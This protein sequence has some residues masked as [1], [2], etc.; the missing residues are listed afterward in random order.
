[1]TDH[2]P[3]ASQPI[4]R[5]VAP[6]V[7]PRR[8]RAIAWLVA[9]TVIGLAAVQFAVIETDDMEAGWRVPTWRRH[10]YMTFDYD[11]VEFAEPLDDRPTL[12]FHGPV[13]LAV[14]APFWLRRG[15]EARVRDDV[16]RLL[17]DAEITRAPLPAPGDRIAAPIVVVDVRRTRWWWLPFT[18]RIGADAVVVA[19]DPAAP[20]EWPSDAQD[21]E[22]PWFVGHGRMGVE[23]LH[24]KIYE[25]QGFAL[26]GADVAFLVDNLASGLANALVGVLSPQEG[27]GPVFES[28]RTR[29][30]TL[31]SVLAA[32]L[33]GGSSG[34]ATS[35]VSDG[36]TNESPCTG[37]TDTMRLFRDADGW[38][39]T[40]FLEGR[41]QVRCR[42]RFRLHNLG[43]R[44][45]TAL[46]A[47]GG[48]NGSWLDVE[49]WQCAE[50]GG[51]P[52]PCDAL[53]IGPGGAVDVE[54]DARLTGCDWLDSS[55]STTVDLFAAAAVGDGADKQQV[56]LHTQLY[57]EGA[58]NADC[59][60]RGPTAA[61]MTRVLDAIDAHRAAGDLG[62][63]AASARLDRASARYESSL[64]R[65][66]AASTSPLDHARIAAFSVMI[67]TQPCLGLV[68]FSR[69]HRSGAFED[70]PLAVALRCRSEG[71]PTPPGP[72]G[73]WVATTPDVYGFRGVAAYAV[74]DLS[75]IDGSWLTLEGGAELMTGWT[76]DPA[77][78]VRDGFACGTIDDPSG[79]DGGDTAPV[80]PA[81]EPGATMNFVALDEDGGPIETAPG[82]GLP[83]AEWWPVS[84]SERSDPAP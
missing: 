1:M 14:R 60:E 53:S 46:E 31:A 65:P 24:G 61:A 55:S 49:R 45:V 28:M 5:P 70:A 32:D 7:A 25:R 79:G 11:Q 9:A 48:F 63:A 78:E 75:G 21:V 26:P 10:D 71:D 39:Q 47:G 4:A 50:P 2:D 77:G 84:A 40:I 66:V 74:R 13:A 73:L 27:S 83:W 56:P 12:P 6:P 64:D 35:I 76:A 41:S 68:D 37:T 18:G 72:L 29:R 69:T 30:P 33:A 67:G 19:L 42:W 17:P 51:A 3:A 57:V 58:P 43:P 82:V 54:V 8:R 52:G 80:A 23:L 16:Q 81:S 36:V 15:L 59:R 34:D 44:T 62:P 20:F 22:P 38:H